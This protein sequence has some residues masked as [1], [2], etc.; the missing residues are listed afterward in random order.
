MTLLIYN[1]KVGENSF[2]YELVIT[3]GMSYI[4]FE[5]PLNLGS[6]IKLKVAIF[7]LWCLWE[8]I[9]NQHRAQD[10][11]QKYHSPISS[12]CD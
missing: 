5:A 11:H 12:Q 8:N 9:C 10:P 2:D 6:T 7:K 3:V 1:V 4:D